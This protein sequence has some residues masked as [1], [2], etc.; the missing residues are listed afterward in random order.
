MPK[1]RHFSSG[2]MIP[3]SGIINPDEKYNFK[4]RM[5][6]LMDFNEIRKLY[7]INDNI[8]Y[9]QE[10]ISKANAK[11]GKLPNVLMQYYWQL[12][13]HFGLNHAYYDFYSPGKLENLVYGNYLSFCR[14]KYEELY[15]YIDMS[16]LESDNPPVYRRILNGS[17]IQDTLDSETLEKFLYVMAYWQALFWLPYSKS[18]LMCTF[19]QTEKIQKKF[20]LKPYNL[21]KWPQ[22]YG[23]NDDEIICICKEKCSSQV[24]YACTLEDQF[25][26]INDVLY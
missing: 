12:G 22:F 21:P 2:F 18:N 5:E 19:Q 1:I 23:N 16:R 13:K 17:T 20:R 7:H 10:T 6:N 15:W 4:G 8:G 14:S 3:R 26:E 24:F 11:F 25:K 9:S